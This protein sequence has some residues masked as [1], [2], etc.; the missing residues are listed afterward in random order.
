MLISL[1]NCSRFKFMCT[2]LTAGTQRG[3][4][5]WW[6]RKGSTTPAGPLLKMVTPSQSHP[7]EGRVSLGYA[8]LLYLSHSQASEGLMKQELEILSVCK[9]NNSWWRI[10]F[11]EAIVHLWINQLVMYV[12]ANT[13]VWCNFMGKKTWNKIGGYSWRLTNFPTASQLPVVNFYPT[14]GSL[15]FSGPVTRTVLHDQGW[16]SEH[17]C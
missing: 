4:H 8:Q 5:F 17:C 16:Y 14:L 10:Q 6:E 13:A 9:Q 7:G 1:E 3:R 2:S 15:K 12:G 11:Y